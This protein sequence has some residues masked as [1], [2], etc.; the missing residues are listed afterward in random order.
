MPAVSFFRIQTADVQS[1]A[2]Y[3]YFAQNSQR[4]WWAKCIIGTV[5]DELF[6]SGQ[7]ED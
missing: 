1:A 6:H 7:Y 4:E 2:D 3:R 5:W